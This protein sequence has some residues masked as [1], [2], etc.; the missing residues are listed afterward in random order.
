MGLCVCAH[1]SVP[2]HVC[3]LVK[4]CMCAC[5]CVHACSCACSSILAK[6]SKC[7]NNPDPHVAF[8]RSRI[9]FEFGAK[10]LIFFFQN[11]IFSSY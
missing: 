10:D 6:I 11:S 5:A 4:A 8:Q 9:R 2:A 7:Q 3:V 1:A